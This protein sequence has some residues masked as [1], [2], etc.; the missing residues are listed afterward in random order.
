M[1]VF[2]VIPRDTIDAGYCRC[3]VWEVDDEM[4]T[5]DRLICDPGVLGRYGS[6]S[7]SLCR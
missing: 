3:A 6:V 5:L 1:Y 4:E 7:D 2:S